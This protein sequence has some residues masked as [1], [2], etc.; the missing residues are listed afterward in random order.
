MALHSSPNTTLMEEERF[1]AMIPD[2]EGVL[3]QMGRCPT[4]CILL[5]YAGMVAVEGVPPICVR[6]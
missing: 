5:T 4:K 1:K 6:Y 2:R 3:P